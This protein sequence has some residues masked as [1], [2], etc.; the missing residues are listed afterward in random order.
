MCVRMA[1]LLFIFILFLQVIRTEYIS[2]ATLA[3]VIFEDEEER[4]K[5]KMM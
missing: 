3:S 5:K 2:E 1:E 4:K